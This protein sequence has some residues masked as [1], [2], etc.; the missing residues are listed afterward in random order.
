MDW[1]FFFFIHPKQSRVAILFGTLNPQLMGPRG[2]LKA[3]PTVDVPCWCWIS[4]HLL[5]CCSYS[6]R[7]KVS[8]NAQPR[9]TAGSALRW[10]HTREYRKA[11]QVLLISCIKE[12]PY[13][14][15]FRAVQKTLTVHNLSPS[16]YFFSTLSQLVTWFPLFLI[17]CNTH[18]TDILYIRAILLVIAHQS[19]NTV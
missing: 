2:I 15:S 14:V 7:C 5:L 8:R 18:H 19:Q 17:L 11:K 1:M 16:C 10:Q 4:P 9:R 6:L 13:T 3:E 12:I